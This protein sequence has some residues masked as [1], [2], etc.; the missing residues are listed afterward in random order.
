M[1]YGHIATD[2]VIIAIPLSVIWRLQMAFWTKARL[3]VLFCVAFISITAS[4]IRIFPRGET[5]TTWQGVNS[6]VTVWGAVDAVTALMV[7]N[8]P[9]LNMLFSSKDHHFHLHP[10]LQP[11]WH[12]LSSTFNRSKS[13]QGRTSDQ[14]SEKS[15]QR[16]GS[17]SESTNKGKAAA[18][19]KEEEV[20]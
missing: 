20:V 17:D 18:H 5:D 10:K 6:R 9:A 7:A 1:S 11:L 14:G 12:S 13:N 4:I 19:T 3:S 16:R 8:L 2:A 15:S